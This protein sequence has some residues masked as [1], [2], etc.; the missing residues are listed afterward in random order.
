VGLFQKFEKDG[1]KFTKLKFGT[2]ESSDRVSGG[3][4]SQPYIVTQIG[5]KFNTLIPTFDINLSPFGLVQSGNVLIPGLLPA[6]VAYAGSDFI[7]RGGLNFPSYVAQDVARLSKF[8]GDYKSASGILFTAKQ[9]ILSKS[10]PQTI[11]STQSLNRGTLASL[12]GGNEGLYTPRGTLAQASIVGLGGHVKKQDYGVLNKKE[13]YEL[14]YEYRD[15][16]NSLLNYT[17]NNITTTNTS[18]ILTSYKGGPGSYLGLLG[19][20]TINLQELR[21]RTPSGNSFDINANYATFTPLQ[22]ALQPTGSIGDFRTTLRQ[23]IAQRNPSI[24]HM[25]PNAPQYYDSASGQFNIDQRVLTGTPSSLARKQDITKPNKIKNYDYRP[26]VKDAL[27]KITAL[28][29]Y[30]SE[31]VRPTEQVNDL[32]K[33]RIAAIDNDNPKNNVYIHFRAFLGP[34]TDNYNA[35]WNP[36]K[37]LGRGDNMYTY[38]GFTRTIGMSW[39]VPAQSKD[40]LIPMY[41]KLNFLASNL[42]PD[43]SD[44]GYMR[45]PLVN[46]TVGGY[47]Y[48]VPGF[49]TSLTYTIDENTTWEIG[50][51]SNTSGSVADFSD[52]YVKELPHV[53]NV[54]SF[55]FTPLH[56]FVPRKQVNTY[57]TKLDSRVF[58]ANEFDQFQVSNYG[59][60]RFI[61]LASGMS[62]I[63]NNYDT[64]NGLR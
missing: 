35:E 36:T 8:F 14:A 34:M 20:T 25:I 32:V 9:S 48:E 4:S 6:N 62:D 15:S 52:S 58:G 29:L 56:R 51:K 27:D 28:P 44:V 21:L 64:D 7:Y 39:V 26:L 5:G 61:S 42:A 16:N 3:N 41:Q 49:I 33:F 37:L 13:Y 57:A 50:I 1:T 45:G 10:A 12:L 18:G 38:N 53:I 60:T 55:N 23:N 17:T 30:K 11:V 24:W 40:E 59:Q 19:N 43:Y 63:N 31:V 22:I 46:L 47:L 2:K 54:S